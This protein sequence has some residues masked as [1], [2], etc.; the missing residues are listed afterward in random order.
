MAQREV[1]YIK[2]ELQHLEQDTEGV[3]QEVLEAIKANEPDE[4]IA[5]IKQKKARLT[6]EKKP[7]R[8][9]LSALQARVASP[10][11]EILVAAHCVVQ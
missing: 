11:G 10:S 2:E 7:L 4:V 1:E 9:D 5:A 8:N 6:D 3:Q